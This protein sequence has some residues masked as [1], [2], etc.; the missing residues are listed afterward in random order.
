MRLIRD[1]RGPR[2][3]RRRILAIAAACVVGTIGCTMLTVFVPK[4]GWAEEWGP[5]VPHNTF[6]GACE[7]CHLPK[8][9]DAIRKDFEFEH[10]K[11]TGFELEGAHSRAACLRCHN[12]R[13]PV[14]AYLSR[15]CNGCH[16]DPHKSSLGLE[17]TDCHNQTWWEPDGLIAE[18]NMTRFPLLASHAFTSCESC[19][20]RSISGDFRGA[21]VECHLCH[22]EEARLAQPSHVNNGWVRDCDDCHDVGDWRAIGFNHS[23]YPLLGAHAVADCN[24]CHV[25]GRIAGTPTDCFSCHQS[26]Y[27]NSLNPSHVV[28]GFPTDC[29]QCHDTND[30]NIP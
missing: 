26:D 2:E 25:G 4:H 16:V 18:H 10:A 17:C 1:R 24:Q 27:V 20:P 3:S 23:T 11:E 30:W 8:S 28:G 9:W 29:S 22:Q 21:P 14:L 12:D 19:H 6:P 5:M 15:G 13:G 7:I